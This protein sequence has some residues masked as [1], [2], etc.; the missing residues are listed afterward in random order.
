LEALISGAARTAFKNALKRIAKCS[1]A[2]QRTS[3]LRAL[4]RHTTADVQAAP[5]RKSPSAN[6]RKQ[7]NVRGAAAR[8]SV[9]MN[10]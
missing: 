2:F 7:V 9:I 4:S 10:K 1:A 3:T 6:R 5:M 8:C